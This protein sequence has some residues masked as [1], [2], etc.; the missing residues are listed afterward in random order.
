MNL[1]KDFVMKALKNVK[2]DNSANNKKLDSNELLG[3]IN[4]I[5]PTAKAVDT[6]ADVVSNIKKLNGGIT[7]SAE[8]TPVK[9]TV[10]DIVQRVITEAALIPA[11]APNAF[12]LDLKSMV[13]D[14]AHC[15]F[16]IKRKNEVATIQLYYPNANNNITVKISIEG[17]DDKVYEVSLDDTQYTMNFGA[18]IIK[19]VDTMLQEKQAQP[20]MG[21][22]GI[23]SPASFG[24]P[25]SAPNTSVSGFSPNWVQNGYNMES[26]F[27]T[28]MAIVEQDEGET[29]EEPKPEGGDVNADSSGFDANSFA[30]DAGGAPDAGGMGG[31]PDAG[32]PDAGAGNINADSGGSVGVEESDEYI[33]DFIDYALPLF[34]TNITDDMF[35]TLIDLLDVR[36][37]SEGVDGTEGVTPPSRKNP[38]PGL[39]QM[40]PKDL[41]K[42]FVDTYPILGGQLK[43]SQA[44]AI[45]ELISKQPS[46]ETFKMD[47]DRVIGD[48]KG[49]QD[50]DVMDM[51][52]LPTDNI[53]PMGGEQPATDQGMGGFGGGSG[54]FGGDM[55]GGFGGD[56]GDMGDM[57]GEPTDDI[58][59][60]PVGSELTGGDIGVEGEPTSDI[61]AEEATDEDVEGALKKGAEMGVP[62]KQNEFQNI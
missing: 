51:A 16:S 18:S 21:D 58:G 11:T 19:S 56:M 35:S 50:A 45:I 57:G 44:D 59:G 20:D 4:K 7:E 30:A 27:K 32:A 22:N 14:K 6:I 34:T 9:S 28:A 52:Q 25:S 5:I 2:I 54:G 17:V 13:I 40:P 3:K 38:L 26:V 23:M 31:A 43:K 12:R 47:L 60:G 42:A 46:P 53:A 61:G 1:D 10:K 33:D 37:K 15:V 24:T 62:P 29:D 41:L 8:W 49:E 48:I 36:Q 55:G 39:K